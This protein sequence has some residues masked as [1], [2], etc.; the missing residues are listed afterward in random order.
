MV[1]AAF[2][3]LDALPLTPNG[4]VDRRALPEPDDEA[5]AQAEYEA[6]QGETEQT[7]AALWAELLGVER[8][9]RHDNFFA[10]GGHS[11]LATQL[12][13]RVRARFGVELPLREL[14]EAPT[15]AGFAPRIVG[16]HAANAAQGAEHAA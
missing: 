4:K 10:L 8:V 7:I 16:A 12:M 1:P 13:S 5:F 14:F 11:L 9:G 3:V 15:I 6:P 2:V